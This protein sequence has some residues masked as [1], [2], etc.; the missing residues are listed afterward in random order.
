MRAAIQCLIAKDKSTIVACRSD[1]DL[2]AR[3][4]QMTSAVMFAKNVHT[5][6]R[7]SA[8]AGMEESA[9]ALGIECGEYSGNGKC[10]A[11][12]RA[13][14]LSQ[15]AQKG[16]NLMG[17]AAKEVVRPCLP[18]GFM[19]ILLGQARLGHSISAE[20]VY[21]LSINGFPDDFPRQPELDEVQS[22]IEPPKD[23]IGRDRESKDVR[24]LLIDNKVV[25]I[26]GPGGVGKSSLAHWLSFD[27]AD[28]YRDGSW[29]IDLARVPRGGNVAVAIA[30]DLKLAGIKDQS[31][32]DRVLIE[33]N[34]M[35]GLVWLD[36]CEHLIQ[37][38]KTLLRPVVEACPNVHFLLTSREPLEMPGEAIYY[39]SPFAIPKP[40]DDP[41]DSEAVRLFINRAK[42]VCLDFKFSAASLAVIAEI[43][44]DVNGLPLAIELAAAQ[45]ADQP[46]EE[47]HLR[48]GVALN[49]PQPGLPSRHRTLSI[50][51]GWSYSLLNAK[52]QKFFR[53]LGVVVGPINEDLAGAIGAGG[54]KADSSKLLD[55]LVSASLLQVTNSRGLKFYQ[56]LEPVRQFAQEQLERNNELLKAKERFAKA[57]LDWLLHLQNEKLLPNRWLAIVRRDAPNLIAA[58]ELNL[59]EVKSGRD[60]L[61]FCVLLFDLWILDGPYDRGYEYFERALA[62]GKSTPLANTADIVMW[63]GSLA[64]YAGKYEKSLAAFEKAIRMHHAVGN[65]ERE[66]I[67]LLNMAIHL[68]NAGDIERALAATEAY[69]S[70]EIPNDP[71][72][73]SKLGNYAWIL[74][75][76]NQFDR[77]RDLLA[78]AM[79]ANKEIMDDWTQACLYA[80]MCQLALM[81]NNTAA[82]EQFLSLALEAY[83]KCGNAQ[84]LIGTIEVAGLI[85]LRVGD[86]ERAARLLGGA[87]RQ[88][89]AAGVG[90]PPVD[91]ERVNHAIEAIVESLGEEE[92]R[93]LFLMGALMSLDD[94]YDYARAG[95]L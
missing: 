61:S 62:I 67:A 58:L 9:V 10:A 95:C 72:R 51:L 2:V 8:S 65:K 47:I 28:A 38:C 64:G 81:S 4:S 12:D 91:Q 71:D 27:L 76:M 56:L 50:A 85:A 79:E 6:I 45:A 69:L 55:R 7:K 52:E 87:E 86:L 77:A 43:C 80:Q 89:V 37:E 20:D 1:D 29:R 57:C 92:A 66:C 88:F 84:G 36:N 63:S 48:L 54:S 41:L 73:A 23:F 3:F 82:A 17:R 78:E 31:A 93:A 34:T 53:N 70:F 13:I 33:F 35:E 11:M 25:S 49:T 15:M 75:E 46:V 18:P 94:S 90:R 32:L 30:A 39:L 19:L 21:Q 40:E 60:A 5:S 59:T 74:A 14:E 26:V 24:R 16:Q 22:N 68:R 42:R 44:R 83:K